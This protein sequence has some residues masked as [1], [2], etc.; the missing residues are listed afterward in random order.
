MLSPTDVADALRAVTG[1]TPVLAPTAIPANWTASVALGANAYDLTYRPP[2]GGVVDLSVSI[3]NLPL[4]SAEGSFRIFEFRGDTGADYQDQDRADPAARQYLIW[5]EPGR[6]A[7]DPGIAGSARATSVPY[8]LTATGVTAIQFQEIA[9]SLH[10]VVAVGAGP[11][12]TAL[13]SHGLHDGQSVRVVLSG[14]APNQRVRLSECA[15]AAAAVTNPAGC[16]LQPAQQ[17]FIDLDDAGSGTI[18]FVA[19]DTAATKLLDPAPPV[20]CTRTCVLVAAEALPATVTAPLD[21]G[22]APPPTQT[23]VSLDAVNWA[24]VT[25]PMTQC[26]LS[27]GYPNPGVPVQ[28]VVLAQPETAVELAIVVVSCRGASNPPTAVFVYDGATSVTTPHLAQTL[29]TE[30]DYWVATGPPV[31]TGPNLTLHATGYGPNDPGYL[32]SVR[33]T[34]TWTWVDGSYRETSAEPPH[35]FSG[36]G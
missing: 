2:G 28:P 34:L 20:A 17:P 12:L 11:T 18:N 29:V 30:H 10:P 13:P 5:F 6:W 15:S 32:P 26:G 4:V 3:P 9:D 22:A 33:A 1:V 35:Q 7:G 21:F 27:N 19:H 24:S 8:E 31:V 25:F 16:G 23:A 14:F 36:P